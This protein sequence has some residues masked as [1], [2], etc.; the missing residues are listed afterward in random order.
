[1]RN[2][3]DAIIGANLKRERQA[4]AFTIDRLAA[5]LS[6]S[7]LELARTEAGERGL[8]LIEMCE[9]CRALDIPILRLLKGV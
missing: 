6:L 1:M 4:A 2:E 3:V 7:S 8:G 9:A 5:I